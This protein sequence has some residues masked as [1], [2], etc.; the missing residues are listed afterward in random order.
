MNIKKY[1]PT[2][3]YFPDRMV[4]MLLINRNLGL[5]GE[6]SPMPGV[7]YKLPTIHGS[8]DADEVFMVF[9]EMISLIIERPRLLYSK[10]SH[11]NMIGQ[12]INMAV[13]QLSLFSRTL[14]NVNMTIQL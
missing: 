2:V 14:S 6:L 10:Y 5:L 9:V 1:I 4:I 8:G 11:L 12:K 3:Q 13:V 7:W